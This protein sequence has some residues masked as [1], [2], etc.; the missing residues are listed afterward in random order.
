MLRHILINWQIFAV[1][2]LFIIIFTAVFTTI[3]FFVYKYLIKKRIKNPD[4]PRKVKLP[5]PKIACIVLLLISI[6]S[7]ILFISKNFDWQVQYFESDL[8]CYYEYKNSDYTE[9]KI[10]ANKNNKCITQT[11]DDFDFTLYENR[12]YNQFMEPHGA[13]NKYFIYI[14]YTGKDSNNYAGIYVG[15]C[16]DK[17]EPECGASETYK[18]NKSPF[19]F[20]GTHD[21]YTKAKIEIRLLTPEDY[22]VSGDTELQELL[23]YKKI[24]IKIDLKELKFTEQNAIRKDDTNHAKAVNAMLSQICKTG[25]DYSKLYK[26]YKELIP[27][28]IY[29]EMNFKTSI[30]N[31]KSESFYWT[32]P[33]MSKIEDTSVIYYKIDYSYITD[34]S[35]IPTE[36]STVVLLKLSSDGKITNYGTT[37]KLPKWAEDFY[38]ELEEEEL[39][40]DQ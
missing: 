29:K 6:V 27:E 31:I 37:E 28:D 18:L 33:Q 12:N 26:D 23:C 17:F 39:I 21:D 13:N 2:L 15:F 8:H 22:K 35:N 34:N 24:T 11:I 10:K 1:M 5:S 20:S 32:Y 19:V 7:N 38:G 36:N 25:D 4:K 3:Y 9:D 16:N 14:N 30:Q 40:Q